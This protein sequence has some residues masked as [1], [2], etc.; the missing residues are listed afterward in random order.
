MMNKLPFLTYNDLPDSPVNVTKSKAIP[1]Y[2]FRTCSFSIGN[3][4]SVIYNNLMHLTINNADYKQY[5]FDDAAVE[6]FIRAHFPMYLK[7]YLVLK[8]GAFRADLWRLLVLYKYGG[9]YND[10]GHQYLKRIDDMIDTEKDE[11]VGIVDA[12]PTFAIHNAMFAVY[13]EHPIMKAMIDTVIN[14]I[15]NKYYGSNPLEVTGPFACG[16]AFN[17]Y[18]KQQQY[19]DIKVGKYKM[20]TH[21]INMLYLSA[22]DYNP[23]NWYII[24]LNG[25]K[26]VKTKF[27]GYY[28]IVYNNTNLHYGEYYRLGLVYNSPVYVFLKI[29]MNIIMLYILAIAF[30]AC[31]LMSW[32]PLHTSIV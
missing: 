24:D 11:F 29:H 32:Q 6:K 26:L 25:D 21:K 17:D 20:N 5:Y 4:P 28:S 8:P 31:I 13:P 16:Y 2:V 10:I 12:Q 30:S 18:F 23:S 22:K 14:N 15:S 7:H 9:I 27:D 19:A 1:K 3:M